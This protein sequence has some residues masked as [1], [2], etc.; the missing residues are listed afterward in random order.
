LEEFPEG[1]RR[2]RENARS[3]KGEIEMVKGRHPRRGPHRP[4]LFPTPSLASSI[5]KARSLLRDHR[6]S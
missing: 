1:P 4:V 2:H 5:I 6:A 3:P